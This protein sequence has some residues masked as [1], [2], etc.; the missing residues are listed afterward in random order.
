LPAQALRTTRESLRA[1]YAELFDSLSASTREQM[2]AVW[3]SEETQ[4]VLR[5]L[6]EQLAAKKKWPQDFANKT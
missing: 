5:A 6:M 3:Y 1:D 2:T 4:Q